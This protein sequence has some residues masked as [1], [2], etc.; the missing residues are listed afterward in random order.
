MLT[1]VATDDDIEFTKLCLV[2]GA[3]ANRNLFKGYKAALAAVAETAS[4]EMARLLFD[5]GAKMKGGGA[6]V[7]A[8]QA[9]KMEMVESLLGNYEKEFE[10]QADHSKSTA[11]CL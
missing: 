5:N 3:D 2:H 7:L 1:C 9:R 11:V 8:A 4:M 10:W 6:T